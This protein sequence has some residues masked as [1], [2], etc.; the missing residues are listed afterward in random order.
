MIQ[1]WEFSAIVIC[2]R[3]WLSNKDAGLTYRSMTLRKTNG[4]G[5]I[6]VPGTPVF[7][8]AGGVVS[9]DTIVYIDGAHKNLSGAPT[10]RR[11]GR[12]LDGK[13]DHKTLRRSNGASCRLILTAR[14]RIA[15]GTEKDRIIRQTDNPYNHNGIGYDGRPSEPSPVTF[16]FDAQR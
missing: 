8:H 3:E 9:D 13:I 7:G 11:P 2:G 14:Y 4:A 12:V 6:P 10:L 5:Q 16:A 1:Y 15:A